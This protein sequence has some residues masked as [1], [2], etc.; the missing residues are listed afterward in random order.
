MPIYEYKCNKCY[1]VKE[2]YLSISQMED[3]IC[4]YCKCGGNLIKIPST[5]SFKI[6]GYSE[7][8]GYSKG[9]R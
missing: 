3:I 7:A 2:K 6:N 9:N 8:N 1:I 4:M 5:G